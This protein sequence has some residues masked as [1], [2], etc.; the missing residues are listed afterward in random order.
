MALQALETVF[1]MVTAPHKVIVL[2]VTYERWTG[3]LPRMCV[4]GLVRR[5][6]GPKPE[7]ILVGGG[8]LTAHF[9]TH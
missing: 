8:S 3:A 6:L 5:D 1:A 7:A 2:L 9:T 4:R